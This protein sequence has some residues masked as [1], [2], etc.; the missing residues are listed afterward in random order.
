M[1]KTIAQGRLEVS[2]LAKTNKMH[3][4]SCDEAWY[5]I[6]PVLQAPG[7]PNLQ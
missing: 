7:Q 4:V 2:T 6:D 5:L 1:S 3:T